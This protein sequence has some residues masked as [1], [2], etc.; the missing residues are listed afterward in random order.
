[1]KGSGANY[2]PRAPARAPAHQPWRNRTSLSVDYVHISL[3]NI[4]SDLTFFT[5]NCFQLNKLSLQR[6][7]STCNSQHEVRSTHDVTADGQSDG[8]CLRRRSGRR[9]LAAYAQE[10]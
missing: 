1:M 4:H 6:G 9:D 5:V 3:E 10:A 8:Y 7:L 2:Y